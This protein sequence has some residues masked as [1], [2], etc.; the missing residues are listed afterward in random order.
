MVQQGSAQL[1]EDAA[2]APALESRRKAGG[3]FEIESVAC[4]PLRKDQEVLGVV[5]LVNKVEGGGFDEDDLFFLASVT[6][7][8]AVALHNANLLESERKVHVLDALLKVSQEI[9]ST[10]DLDHV[11]TTVV[12]QAATLVPFDRC[13]IGFFDRSRFILGA[14]SGETAVPKS[15]E[16]D[17]LTDI[18]E[19]SAGQS[20][21]V[22]ADH[23]EEGW[24]V[25]PEDGRAQIVGF[26]EAH[27]YNGFY[28]LPLR[29]E[30]GTLGT[31][32]L[33]SSD[34]DFLAASH[35]ETLAILANQV[36]VAI[37]NAQLYQQMPLAGLW[38][39]FAERKRSC[40]RR[41]RSRAGSNTRGEQRRSRSCSS[42]FPGR[43]AWGRTRQLCPRKGVWSAQLWAASPGR[44]SSTKATR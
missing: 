12:H 16:M 10:L 44:F 19:W 22:S 7:Q 17:D 39:P 2:S 18:L 38:Q 32:A 1:V 41:C 20:E 43:C 37:R 30:Q 14:V 31:L 21:A 27:E 26:L 4:A 3:D 24:E 15:R 34:A 36:T 8:A 9:T 33:L 35:R 6:E 28:A 5:E 13:V 11:L 40:W 23:Y 29:D 25:T 42:L